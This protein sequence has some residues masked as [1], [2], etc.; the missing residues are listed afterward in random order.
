MSRPARIALSALGLSFVFVLTG[1]SIQTRTGSDEVVAGTDGL[2][3]LHQGIR[4]SISMDLS[5]EDIL[6]DP[7]LEAD[8]ADLMARINHRRAEARAEAAA[9][10]AE[11]R[12]AAAAAAIAARAPVTN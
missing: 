10:A 4:T 7:K 1:L 11:D 3:T 5:R 12:A 2:E 6:R 9:K 8:H